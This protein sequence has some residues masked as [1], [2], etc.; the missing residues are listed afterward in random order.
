MEV[1]FLND[2]VWGIDRE[3]CEFPTN[4]IAAEPLQKVL[5]SDNH[6]FGG[7]FGRTKNSNLFAA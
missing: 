3:T 4:F 6:S 5:N 1:D 7:D 2:A